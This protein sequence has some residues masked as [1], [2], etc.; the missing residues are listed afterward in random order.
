MER[1]GQRGK[2]HG[3]P[4]RRARE[5]GKTPPHHLAI[6][7]IAITVASQSLIAREAN[8]F[9]LGFHRISK[10]EHRARWRRR[11]GGGDIV[12]EVHQLV[13]PIP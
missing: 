7:A 11:G 10:P 13:E 3:G 12:A 6:V 5:G 1:G 2:G 4:A 9:L 8:P